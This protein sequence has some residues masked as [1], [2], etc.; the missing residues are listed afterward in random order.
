VA[1][2]PTERMP[3]PREALPPEDDWS[4]MAPSKEWLY[5]TGEFSGPHKAECDHVFGWVKG[6]EPCNA[7]LCEHGRDLAAEWLTRCTPFEDAPLVSAAQSLQTQLA[8]RSAEAATECGKRL[9]GMVRD[10]CGEDATCAAT[11][12]RWATRCA[13]TE[14]TP[15]VMR[16]LQRSLER[17]AEQG[18][19]PVKLDPRTCDELRKDLS[20]AAR[21]K[22]RFACAEAVPRVGIYRDRCESDAERPTIAT[23]VAELTV[24]VGGSK[25]AESI[26]VQEGSPTLSPSDVPVGL[27]DGAGGVIYVC[28]E[29]ASDLARYVG[30]RKS[31]A[32]GKMVVARAFPTAKGIEVKVGTLEFPDD[33]SF[34]ARYPTIVAAG[35]LDQR[36]KEAAGALDLAA[37]KAAELGKSSGNVAEA[38]RILTA[39]VLS[40]TLS[41]KRSAAARD[42]LTRRDELLVP[43]M[44]EIARAKAAAARAPRVPSADAAGLL[45]RARS[46]AF[47][48]LF[49]D[50][51]VQI[52]AA[53]RALTLGTA[54]ILPRA[55][56]A[57]LGVLKNAKPRKLDPRSA[58]AE[59]ARGIAAAQTCGASVKKL[60]ESK[61]ALLGCNFGLEVCEN[62][63]QVALGKAVDDARAAA[64]NAFR[65]LETARTADPEDADT[66]NRAAESASCREPWW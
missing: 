36:D 20:E 38:A 64:E 60:Q 19:E 46:R 29:R 5:A 10:G 9:E 7:S 12:Q 57:Y 33:S 22:D 28:E 15:L 52:G 14:G 51:S 4:R 34:S 48:D 26:L 61:K 41:I 55:M 27:S 56:E 53:T 37:G 47:A 40:H 21:C 30:A 25:P 17:K 16:I 44:K 24:L 58:G 63:R 59:K 32:A 1:G 11:A 45:A 18:S 31:C 49:P 3:L 43:V 13:K 65:D 54:A 42:A 8:G 2:C 23:A 6:E 50:G 66:I 35:E 62:A 39:A